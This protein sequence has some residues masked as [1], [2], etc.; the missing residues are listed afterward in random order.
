MRKLKS[1]NAI[2]CSIALTASVTSQ[3][4]AKLP[5]LDDREWVG[6]YKV[7]ASK[8]FAFG[9]TPDGECKL[10][11]IGKEGRA[12]IHDSIAVGFLIEEVTPDGKILT[13]SFFPEFLE[14]EQPASVSIKDVTIKGKAQDDVLFELTLTEDRG[15]I[16]LGGKVTSPGKVQNPLRLAISVKIPDLTPGDKPKEEEDEKKAKKEL[17]KLL[18]G[19]RLSVKWIDGKSERPTATE[20][21]DASSAAVSGPG[22]SALSG[23]FS[24]LG[25]AKLEFAAAPNSAMTLSNDPSKPLYKGFT[26][27]WR[28][29]MAKDPQ[30]KARLSLQLK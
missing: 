5:L 29:D 1:M 10:F 17:E 8:K 9:I 11:A 28:P 30:S 21:I 3:C 20:P 16:L 4:L 23:E 2:W 12:M 26:V 18:K 6:Y 15:G 14:S 22:I 13:K 25:G 24:K 19:E 27:F 7:A